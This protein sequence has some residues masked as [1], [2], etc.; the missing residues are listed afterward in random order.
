[1]KRLLVVIVLAGA[2]CEREPQDTATA[3]PPAEQNATLA[4]Q[5]PTSKPPA[6]VPMPSDKAELDRMILAGYTPHGTHMHPPG[7][8][9][10][11]LVHGTEAVM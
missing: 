8:K 5:A 7:V 10:C 3:R 11:P 9:E 6:I 4:T 1:M 2:A